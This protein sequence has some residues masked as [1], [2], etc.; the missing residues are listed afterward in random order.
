MLKKTNLNVKEIKKYLH[1]VTVVHASIINCHI[2]SMKNSVAQ[3]C[4][5]KLWT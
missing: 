4:K 1:F 2:I 5:V 3:Q